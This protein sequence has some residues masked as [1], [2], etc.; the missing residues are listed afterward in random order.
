MLPITSSRQTF[1]NCRS[2]KFRTLFICILLMA[3]G[4][5]P[6]W[7]PSVWSLSAFSL[8]EGSRSHG[9]RTCFPAHLFG[10]PWLSKWDMAPENHCRQSFIKRL[11]DNTED[12]LLKA[13]KLC[14]AT[15]CL[16]CF[17]W[18]IFLLLYPLLPGWTFQLQGLMN[19]ISKSSYADKCKYCLTSHTSC[20]LHRSLGAEGPAVLTQPPSPVR[21]KR[22]GTHILLSA[23]AQGIWDYRRFTSNLKQWPRWL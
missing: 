11:H 20:M 18:H 7:C 4:G 15:W 9:A 22:A 21:S 10:S 12:V 5:P 17:I 16:S 23:E 13:S 1:Y 6:S 8:L 3:T 19:L 14:R 2:S